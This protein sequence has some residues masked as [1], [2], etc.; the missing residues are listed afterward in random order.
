VALARAGRGRRSC[1]ATGPQ[2]PCLEQQVKKN[3]APLLARREWRGRCELARRR[4]TAPLG[5]GVGFNRFFHGGETETVA[6][7]ERG[8]EGLGFSPS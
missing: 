1:A 8:K 4:A 6:A 7:A 5:H 3:I 2:T